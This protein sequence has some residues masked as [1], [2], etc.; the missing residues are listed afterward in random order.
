[1]CNADGPGTSLPG[2]STRGNFRDFLD[3]KTTSPWQNRT[4]LPGPV[5][6]PREGGS[7]EHS[8]DVTMAMKREK[9]ALGVLGGVGPGR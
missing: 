8:R 6:F 7:L 2:R 1:M 5:N 9:R 4:D 3:G